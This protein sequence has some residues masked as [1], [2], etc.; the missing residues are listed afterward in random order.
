MAQQG[1][2]EVS[3]SKGGGSSAMPHKVN[4]VQAELLGTLGRSVAGQCGVLGQVM[5]HEQE[6]SG[7]AWMLE[8]MVLP[9]MTMAVGCATGAALKALRSIDRIG[10]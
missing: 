10:N 5:I 8:W 6:R 4:P 1:V 9:P 3:L 7:A 2:D